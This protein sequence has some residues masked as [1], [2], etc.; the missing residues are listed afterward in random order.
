MRINHVGEDPIVVID[1]E[2]GRASVLG[3]TPEARK[4]LREVASMQRVGP[5]LDIPRAVAES[6]ALLT[7]QVLWQQGRRSPIRDM[8]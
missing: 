5:P 8:C 4:A 1:L 6:L 7:R 2:N 3:T